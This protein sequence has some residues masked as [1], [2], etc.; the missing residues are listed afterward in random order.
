M[1]TFLKN[2]AI[3][4]FAALMFWGCKGGNPNTKPQDS[5]PIVEDSL[6]APILNVYIE[7]SLSMD[8]YVKGATKFETNISDYLVALKNAD[9][10]NIVDTLNVD[11]T[12]EINIFF[13][14]KKAYPYKGGDITVLMEA[15]EP[16][17]SQYI[18][19]GIDR[20]TTNI[21][22]LIS[23][24]IDDVD[25]ESAVSIFVS[26]CIFSPGMSQ[27]TREYGAEEWLNK[28]RVWLNDA[29]AKKVKKDPTFTMVGYRL[30]SQFRGNFYDKFDQ[31]KRNFVGTRP[32]YIWLMGGRKYVSKIMSE[33][34][35]GENIDMVVLGKVQGEFKDY[36]IEN[37]LHC[38]SFRI[39]NFNTISKA[40]KTKEKGV[41]GFEVPILVDY[42][43]LM[44]DDAYLCDS[45]NYVVSNE[46]YEV[47][48]EKYTGGESGYTH[49]IWLRLT[50][51]DILKIADNLTIDIALKSEKPAWVDEWND[52][53]GD[54]SAEALKKTYGIKDI[55][56]G[57]AL[58]YNGRKSIND[59]NYVVLTIKIN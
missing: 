25:T 12:N 36:K 49:R 16:N 50:N 11:G 32:Y 10:G 17:S 58:G 5:P 51:E 29:V 33:V 55:V 26:D 48:V 57:L 31:K 20:K 21:G 34:P 15:I 27:Q 46:D 13:I 4:F 42:S 9:L 43:G 2:I 41:S 37:S 40:K 54:F 18:V 56:E 7:N 19:G 53:I 23:G 45:G 52:T 38:G 30:E 39:N 1:K 8:G 59:N 14:N 22:E 24:L 44:L 28:Q 3:L 47:S 6:P 35:M